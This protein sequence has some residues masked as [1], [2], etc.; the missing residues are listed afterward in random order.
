[1]QKYSMIGGVFRR[2]PPPKKKKVPPPEWEI[3]SKLKK[4]LG[5][6]KF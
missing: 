4:P 3:L 1:M 2:C 5:K 6:R